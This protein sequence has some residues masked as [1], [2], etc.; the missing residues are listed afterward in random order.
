MNKSLFVWCSLCL[1]VCFTATGAASTVKIRGYVTSIPDA[2]SVA[3][4]DD[5]IAYA[6]GT[7]L[8]N[9][10]ATGADGIGLVVGTLIEAEGLWTAPH[11]FS[12]VKINCDNSQ[13][14]REI[15]ESAYLQ[16]EPLEAAKSAPGTQVRLKADGELLL[17]GESAQKGAARFTEASTETSTQNMVGSQIH[18]RGVRNND[19]SILASMIEVGS[20]APGDAYK[21]PGGITVVPAIEPKSGLRILE[22]RKGDKVH[23]RLKLFPV[24]EVQD[25]VKQLGLSLLPPAAA[26]TK[27]PV[28][29]RF[30]V[31]EDPSINAEALPDGTTFVNTGL[32]AAAQNEAQL[33]FVMSHEIAHVLQA[34]HWR[35]VNDTRAKRVLIT[36]AAIAGSGYIGD[37]SLYLGQ[38]GLATVVNGYS[39]RVENQA[40]RLGLQNTIDHGYDPRP[41][42]AFFRIMVERYR[43]RSTS[44]IWSN[45]ESALTRGSFLTVQLA[46]QYPQERFSSSRVD[47]PAFQAMKDAMGPVKIE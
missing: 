47:T 28:E 3:I 4:L 25:Y 19:G 20:P 16:E 13:F 43:Q 1:L 35:E 18:Y 39:R 34:H 30:F 31:V 27:R 21:N 23:G 44:A 7:Q 29:F 24:T 17:V 41:A 38:I 15:S 37:L 9:C 26:V 2:N 40:D 46:R 6:P 8:Q 36:I 33:A 42:V 32:L 10:A 22:F 45:H 14:T 5:A 12:A 11:R